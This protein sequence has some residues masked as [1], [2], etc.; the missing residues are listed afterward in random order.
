MTSHPY[1][2]QP[3]YA[4]WSR[5]VSR[6]NPS[7][8]DPVVHGKFKIDRNA[9]V[10]TAGSCFAQH[11]ARRLSDSGF[12]FYVTEP[13]HPSMNKELSTEFNYGLFSARYGNI[14]TS[15]QLVQLLRRALGNF[16]PVEK[17]WVDAA[18]QIY[19]PYRPA[20][21]PNGFSSEEEFEADQ[22][23]HLAATLR[24]FSEMDFFIFTLG[25]TEC[26]VSRLDGAAFPSCPGVLA[27]DFDS[28]RHI[29]LNLNVNEVVEDVLTFTQEVQEFNP[30]FKTIITVSP[31]PLAAT[32]LDKHVLTATTYSKSV[33]RVA[34]ELIEK[35]RPDSVAYF[36]SYEIISGNFN[37]GRYYSDD[38]RNVLEN[39]VDHVM[40]LFFKHYTM[41]SGL[42]SDLRVNRSAPEDNFREM[43]RLVQVQCEEAA[44]DS[45]AG[46][47]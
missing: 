36:P 44:L 34:A 30:A 24:A 5:A 27:G 11:I 20:I 29:L 37:R 23:Q 17:M 6:S 1:A 42:P 9:K 4:F 16:N 35:A 31:V 12:N 3:P 46:V 8:I 22:Q 38:L 18:G 10:V 41:S 28:D 19:D 7:D 39:G 15:R 26:W 25:L 2:K 47:A 33:L 43:Q 14:Y 21:Q 45:G 13:P 32:A 40:G